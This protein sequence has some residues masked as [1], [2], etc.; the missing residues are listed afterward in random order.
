[1]VGR[2]KPRLPSKISGK[3]CPRLAAF[4]SFGNRL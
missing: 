2:A 3:D 4:A 1:M